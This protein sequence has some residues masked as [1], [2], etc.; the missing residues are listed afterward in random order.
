MLAAD[1]WLR[2]STGQFLWLLCDCPLMLLWHTALQFL[3]QL[4]AL[5]S[6]TALLL[7]TTKPLSPTN[8]LGAPT[9]ASL[10]AQ[11]AST[12]CTH[13]NQPKMMPMQCD[14]TDDGGCG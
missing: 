1:S 14:S 8:D 7:S 5:S 12:H 10:S 3:A 9:K 2:E 6:H 13:T 4:S 11:Q